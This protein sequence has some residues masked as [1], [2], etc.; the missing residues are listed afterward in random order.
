M[1]NKYG[2][3]PSYPIPIIFIKHQLQ[4]GRNSKL[5]DLVL[6]LNPD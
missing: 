4:I 5:F 3:K 6:L 2:T 1:K